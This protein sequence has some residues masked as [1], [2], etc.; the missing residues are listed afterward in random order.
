MPK[1]QEYIHCC[2]CSH[3]HIEKAVTAISCFYI[4]LGIIIAGLTLVDFAVFI[5]FSNLSFRFVLHF[6]SSI[7]PIIA[8]VF[9]LLAVKYKKSGFYHFQYFM[10]WKILIFEALKHALSLIFARHGPE[11]SDTVYSIL[12]HLLR[13]TDTSIL[14]KILPVTMFAIVAAIC[15]YFQWIVRK[16]WKRSMQTNLPETERS[17]P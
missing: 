14:D 12:K 17:L 15:L 3:V 16:A 13:I 5:G 9:G 6:I 4:V 7:L 10:I 11:S 1:D 8:G 2:G